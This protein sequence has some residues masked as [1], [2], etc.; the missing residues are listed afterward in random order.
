VDSAF[1]DWALEAYARP[2]VEAACLTLQDRHGRSAPF[3]LWAAW[4]AAQGR[5]LTPEGLAEAA[6]LAARWEAAATAPLRQA[7]RA[8]KPP[9][10][11]VP[12][13]GREAL[14]AEVKALELRCE[15]T[16]M[17]ALQALAPAVSGGAPT[18]ENALLQAGRIGRPPAPEAALRRL[19]EAL[20][21]RR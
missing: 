20:A 3:L 19:A 8:L 14:R 16:L 6:D 18:L 4:A 10:P 9:F 11:G 21:E 17:A 1:W 12:D 5:V 2:G 15:Q 7:R 13:P